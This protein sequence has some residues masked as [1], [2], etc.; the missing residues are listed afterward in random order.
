MASFTDRQS[1]FKDVVD[2]IVN[3]VNLRHV[4]KE[5]IT[6]AT[7]LVETGLQLDSLDMLEIVVAVEQRY[8][9]KVNNAEDG[10]RIFR[11]IGTIVDF[12]Q[13]QNSAPNSL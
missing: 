6:E 2:T 10:K 4:N 11:N 12:V 9:L 3:A 8:K 7:A 13:N 5:E 1:L